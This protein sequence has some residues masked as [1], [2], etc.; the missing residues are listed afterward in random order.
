MVSLDADLTPEQA[1]RF[2][3][4]LAH[5]ARV[6]M[7]RHLRAAKAMPL[8]G[9]RAALAAEGIALDA[10]G[11][12]FHARKMEEAGLVDVARDEVRLLRDVALRFRLA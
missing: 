12:R 7:M 11:A 3:A 8:A 1:A 4:G 10:T 9:L 6:A 5:P 2:H